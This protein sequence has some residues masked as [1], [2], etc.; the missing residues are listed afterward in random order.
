MA[1]VKDDRRPVGRVASLHVETFAANPNQLG[2]AAGRRATEPANDNK[3]KGQAQFFH[4]VLH[5]AAARQEPD[6]EHSWLALD[7]AIPVCRNVAIQG[8]GRDLPMSV[9]LHVAALGI[10]LRRLH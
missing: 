5:V 4:Y 8:P 7:P 9:T 10:S 1:T 2:G 6:P 3:S